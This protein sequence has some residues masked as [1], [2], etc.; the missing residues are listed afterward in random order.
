[1]VAT[2]SMD[3]KEGPPRLSGSS[4]AWRAA[5]DA[6]TSARV[7][8]GFKTLREMNI[9]SMINFDALEIVESIGGARRSHKSTC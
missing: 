5:A 8:T 9:G 6:V 7:L 1:M 2:C 3:S 4:R